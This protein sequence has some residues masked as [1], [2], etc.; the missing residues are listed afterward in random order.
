M[1]YIA[2]DH[3]GF[4]LKQELF[5]YIKNNLN[6]EALDLGPKSFNKEDD[7]TDFATLVANRVAK[8]DGAFGI[9]ICGT[10]SGMCITANKIKNIRAILGHSIESAELGRKH[11]NANI[12]CLGARFTTFEHACDIIKKFIGTDFLGEERFNRRNRKI[13][14]LENSL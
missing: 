3:A 7:F 9:L 4:E 12:L 14:D 13:T 2:S 5:N 11:N 1:I 10:G 8:E 6:K